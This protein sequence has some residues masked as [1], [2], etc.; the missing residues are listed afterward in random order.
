MKLEGHISIHCVQLE[1]HIPIH[2]VQLE[3]HIPIH[4]VQLLEGHIP[5]HCVQLEGLIPSNVSVVSTNCL[6]SCIVVSICV[7]NSK[8]SFNYIV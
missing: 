5:I 7:V 3:G 4:C 2:C 1:G 8:G 6:T